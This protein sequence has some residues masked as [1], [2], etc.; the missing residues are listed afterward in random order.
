MRAA[1]GRPR[2]AV[3]LVTAAALALH[4]WT[5]SR[6][7]HPTVTFDET[8]YLG[9][10]RW[11]A[12]SPTRWDMPTSP[13]YA[14]GYPLLLTPVMRLFGPAAAQW[15]AVMVVNS[16]LLASVVPLVYG[17]ARRVLAAPGRVSLLAAAVGAAAPA[18]VAAGPSAIAEN[19]AIPLVAAV[20]LLAHRALSPGPVWA[21]IG[22]GPAVGFLHLVHARFVLVLVLA[23]MLLAFGRWRGL[24]PWSVAAAN[25]GLLAVVFGAGRALTRA[26][27]DTRWTTIEHLEASPGDVVELLRAR[28]GVTTIATT[29]F[30]QAWYLAAG[31]LG[32][33]LVGVVV[34]G[35]RAAR[36]DRAVPPDPRPA[37]DERDAARLT[38]A[39]VLLAAASVF[40]ASV[41]FFAHT[42]FRADHLVYGRHNDTF[43]PLWLASAVVG[44]VLGRRRA[45]ASLAGASAAVT[46]V[47]LGLLERWEDPGAFGGVYSPFAVPAIIRFV[48]DDP[49][50]TWWRA[51][52][53]AVLGAAVVG[54]V[55]VAA[56][57]PRWLAPP[58]IVWFVWAGFGTVTGTDEFED[59]VYRDWIAPEVVRG[60]G[61]EGLSVDSRAVKAA[62]PALS[63]GWALPD[64]DVTT[65][66]PVLGEQPDR[67]F[68]LARA[69]DAARRDAGDRIAWIDRSGYTTFWGAPEG[70]ALWVRPGPEADRLAADGALLPDRYPTG[71]PEAARR[72]EVTLP[73]DVAG[74]TIEVEGGG[75]VRFEVEGRHVGLGSPWPDRASDDGPARVRV[76]ARVDALDP[77]LD[78][79]ATS[80]GELDRWTRPG[81]PFTA[82]VEV[83]AVG[84]MLGDLAPGRYRVT[85][86]VGQDEPSWFAPGGPDATFT[87]VVTG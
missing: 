9:N 18:V 25:A 5:T 37:G 2:V 50:G 23:L 49:P 40:L 69:D 86:G 62:F 11:I 77:G 19:L 41:A 39:F 84:A 14:V 38:L 7:A 34:V 29:A 21:R 46:V 35:C 64:V 71:L 48:G 56:R 22:F 20:A 27:V 57:R 81:E 79:G 12:G 4:L 75:R 32:L 31:S 85:I 52:L 65:F 33:A 6:F 74:E 61:V 30:G 63:Y 44:V 82:T 42:R 47:L 60:L 8:G 1:V 55:A 54:V 66:D 80:G 58:L 43:V 17:F 78:D 73:A 13:T 67:P 68:V 24:V 76:K 3:G 28:A 87:L 15:R 26:V 70:V 45:V 59:T 72:V 16:L 53:A 36:P 83:V 51:T 10:A